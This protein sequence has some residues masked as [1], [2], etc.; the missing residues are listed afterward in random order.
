MVVRPVGVV[1]G[2]SVLSEGGAGLCYQRFGRLVSASPKRPSVSVKG[3]IQCLWRSFNVAGG[4]VASPTRKRPVGVVCVIKGHTVLSKFGVPSTS[5][6]AAFEG[7]VRY[8]QLQRPALYNRLRSLP[9][10]FFT[11][12]SFFETVIIYFLV[13]FLLVC[14]GLVRPSRPTLP[15]LP[16][17]HFVWQARVLWSHVCAIDAPIPLGRRGKRRCRSTL[18]PGKSEC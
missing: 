8:C 9:F 7:P 18:L 1:A 14:R 4:R 12:F 6:P 16:S 15:M 10:F 11:L 13:L 3:I 17:P 2:W 5:G